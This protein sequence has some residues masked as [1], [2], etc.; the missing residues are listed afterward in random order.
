VIDAGVR[1]LSD[2]WEGAIPCAMSL[3]STN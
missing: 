1:E 2:V 3:S